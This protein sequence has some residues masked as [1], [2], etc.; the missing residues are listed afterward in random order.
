M[1]IGCES[2][3]SAC[4]ILLTSRNSARERTKAPLV[5]ACARFHVKVPKS[6]NLARLRTELVKHWCVPYSS[7]VPASNPV[8]RP[9]RPCTISDTGSDGEEDFPVAPLRRPRAPAN[10][11]DVD[12]PAEED[13]DETSLLQTYGVE[14]AGADEIL[15]Y[16]SDSDSEDEEDTPSDEEA[17]HEAFK[18]SVRV[19]AVR[20]AEGNRRAGGLKTQKAMVKAWDEFKAMAL[21][22]KRIKDVIVDE[23]SLLLFIAH[24]AEREKLNRRGEPIPGTRIGASQLKKLFFGA[25]RIRKEQDAADKTLASKRPAATFI[26]WEAIKNRMDEALERVRNGL[27]ETEDAPDIRANTFLAEVTEEQL[28]NIGC[29]FLAHRQL[30]L[31]V[32]GHLAW[33][34]MNATGNRGDD[35]RSLKLAELQPYSMQHPVHNMK[36]FAVLGLQGEEKAGKRG[37]RTVVNPSYST[38]IANKNPQ[39]C[40]LGAFAIYHHY[41]HDE[42]AITKNVDWLR[43]SS[44]RDIRILHGPKSPATPYNEQNFYNLICR[45]YLA[46]GFTTRLKAHLARH[47]LGYRQ[48]EQRVDSNDTA[49]L[50]WKRGQTY[51]DT[52]APALPRKAILGGAGYQATEIYEPTWQ[53]VHVPPHFL[54]LVCPMAEEIRSGKSHLSGADKY[55]EM[56]IE[57]RPYLFQCGAAIYQKCPKSAI[58]RL[59]A[60][61]DPDVLHWMKTTFP[62]Q[63][64]S[65]QATAG[66]P[67]DLAL[68]QNQ[69]LQQSLE[70]MYTMLRTQEKTI[71]DLTKMLER[72][73]AAL[74]PTQGFSDTTYHRQGASL[75]RIYVHSTYSYLFAAQRFSSPPPTSTAAPS[76]P[77]VIHLNGNMEQTGT[78]HLSDDNDANNSIRGFVNSS[79]K[80]PDVPRAPT[81]VDLVLPPTEAF[82]APGAPRGI[83]PPLFGQK[84]ARWPDVFALIRQPKMCWAVWGPSKTVDKFN[85]V[86]EFWTTYV[87]GEPVYNDAGV[88]TGMKPP[89]QLVEQY[90]QASWRTPEDPKRAGIAKQWERYREIP[91]WIH[92]HSTSRGVSPAVIIAELEAVREVNGVR[93]GLNWLRIELEK[94]RK[95]G[96]VAVT[97]FRRLNDVSLNVMFCRPT[98]QPRRRLH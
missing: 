14:G 96:A 40:P 39:M 22:Q 73:T 65:V 48:E 94:K 43:N 50:G 64:I 41:I 67:T 24:N 34:A 13:D 26:V 60:F 45:A 54:R 32:F 98:S 49:K 58:F 57:L 18:K 37:M 80:S 15:G 17:Q 12:T 68:I 55:W 11:S 33:T 93:K 89:L 78:Y 74:S 52:Y 46:V 56:I 77:V 95:E 21:Q 5:D 8:A 35:F 79:P 92:K 44:W 82:F 6:A 59:P 4:R 86:R 7:S 38:F 51:F 16:D 88:Q 47:M 19:K 61:T 28:Q 20:R 87:D 25:L 72:R 31:A 69:I 90:L 3:S 2:Q 84:S 66:S 36:I 81:Q 53:K 83:V 9:A 63:L 30:R 10:P 23:H 76:T 1:S 70:N 71:R 91:Q 75:A 27:D 29:G 62:T 85:D 42:K 97:S